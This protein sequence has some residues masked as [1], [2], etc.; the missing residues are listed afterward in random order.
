MTPTDS[1]FVTLCGINRR[2]EM[3]R[4]M[5]VQVCTFAA[6]EA[7]FMGYMWMT[8]GYGINPMFAFPVATIMVILPYIK[9]IRE[10]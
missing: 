7:A 4:V 8:A 3:L 6:I 5:L 9:I 10:I 1:W 2:T